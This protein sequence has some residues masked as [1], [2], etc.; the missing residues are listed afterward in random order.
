MSQAATLETKL[1]WYLTVA[2]ILVLSLCTLLAWQWQLDNLQT[3]T[4][5]LFSALVTIY[6]QVK[7]YALVN[8]ILDATSLQ[9]EAMGNEEFNSWHF[10]GFK[11]KR[12]D[13][14]RADFSK[15]SEKIAHK[16][17]EY[18]QNEN[19]LFDF[20]ESLSLPVIILDHNDYVF[21]ANTAM[22]RFS[23]GKTLHSLPVSKLG[24]V[25]QNN[26]WQQ[27]DT[28]PLQQ[29]VDVSHR[30]FYRNK[31]RYQLLV[32]LPIEARL[33]DNEKQVWQ[34]L[35]RVINHEIRN[36]LTP[37]S[38]MAQSLIEVKQ[39]SMANANKS[40][41]IEPEQELKI[42][43]V[44]EK[45][46][47]HLLAFIEDYSVFSKIEPAKKVRADS[48]DIIQRMRALF[49]EVTIEIHQQLQLYVDV[50]QLEQALINL[51][52]NAIEA[53]QQTPKIHMQWTQ[54]NQQL[55]ITIQDN[56]T[57]IANPENLFVPFYSTKAQG[58]GVGLV[59]SRELIRNQG[60]DL[61]LNN[62]A[63]CQGA[64]VCITLPVK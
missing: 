40:K 12:I 23:A 35:M 1:R 63:D 20:V 14:L 6:F 58:T 5:F 16:Q 44:I 37:I 21:S 18:V 33:R 38:S 64:I 48:T 42:L 46:A 24:L 4:L 55:Q 60:G 36:S 43:D 3:F 51:I 34:R 26:T 17:Q 8:N 29:R 32:M 53:C 30:A 54:N 7:V 9:I 56:G 13:R 10:A 22:K 11:G 47:A 61:T 50:A 31:H 57:G 62:R 41:T 45:R 2:L 27:L 19:V 49:P 52:K 28:N 25:F 15:L 59:L 39:A